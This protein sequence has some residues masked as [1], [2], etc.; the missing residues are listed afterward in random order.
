MPLT[1]AP[2]SSA[3]VE[4]SGTGATLR[5][6]IGAAQ[7]FTLAFGAIVG[8]GWVV[9]LGEWLRQAGPL[10]AVLGLVGGGMVVV[11]IG[12]CYAEMSTQLPA[13]GG[14]VA[15]AYEVFGEKACFVT[16]WLL[17]LAY[18]AVAAFEAISIGWIASAL[19]PGIDGPVLYRSLGT[20][21]RAGS[22]ALG[23]GGMAVLTW[24]NFRGAKA[25]MRAQDLLVVTLLVIA[26]VFIAAGIARGDTANLRPYFQRSTEG[27]IWP[28]M[29]AVFITAP[30]WF[31]GFEVI[32]KAVEERSQK[33]GLRRVG[34]LIVLAIVIGIAFK[35]LV[36]ISSSMTMPWREL[37]TLD[38]PAAAAFRNA[39]G[40]DVLAKLVLVA[41]LLG[42]LAT[43]NAVLVAASRVLFALGRAGLI[44]PRFRTVHAERGVPAVA[45]LFAGVVGGLGTL[46]GRNGLIPIVNMSAA[47]LTFAYL[48]TCVA[49]I[50][51]R[52]TRPEMARPYRIPGG[53]LTAGLATVGALFVLL[54]A[55]YQPFSAAQGRVPAEWALL[56]VWGALGF[57]FWVLA[58]GVR[59]SIT[60]AER[61][62][63]ILGSVAGP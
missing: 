26:A 57:L 12:V 4:A 20:D 5:K 39:F 17:A 42:L 36:I 2:A 6:E 25:S 54:L 63:L 45:V 50:R 44:S 18:L 51:L 37:M 56:L 9:V 31:G 53:T 47:C 7:F 3:S 35:T 8:V 49:V 33:T 10:G 58:R 60:Q 59:S 55:L 11:L 1:R 40:S 13:A 30:F 62:R 19:M 28:G 23:L 38:L 24:L 16:G 52:L 48:L 29:V 22:L 46:L 32:P 14:E 15:F 61:R 43:W 21:V 41:A 34:T 27:S